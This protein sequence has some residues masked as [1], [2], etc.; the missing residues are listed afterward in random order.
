MVYDLLLKNG[1]LLNPGRGIDRVGD[2]AVSEGKLVYPAGDDIRAKKTVDVTGCFVLPG[3]IDIH[4]HLNYLGAAS[5]MPADLACIPAGVTAVLDAGSTGVSNAPSLAKRLRECEVKTKFMLNVSATG[6]IMANQ[7]PESVDPSVWDVGLF[8]AIFSTYGD[9]I[10][11][12]KIRISKSVV[13]EMGLEPLKKAIELSERYGVPV[14]VHTTNPPVS[15]GEVA[16]VLRKGDILTHLYHGSGMTCI[17]EGKVAAGYW[18]ARKRGVLFDTA[19]GQGNLSLTV[20]GEAIA[21]GFRPDTISTDLNIYN[22]NHDFVF[23]L[24]VMMAKFLA[25]GMSLDEVVDCV[26]E[27]PARQWGAAGDMGCL[28]EGT[29]ADITVLKQIKRSMHYA[30]K[31]GNQI[32]GDTALIPMMTVINGRTR[33]QATELHP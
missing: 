31:Y 30:D 33:Y 20:A 11:A 3:L 17:T 23:S 15:M 6:I 32:T 2:L 1:H 13:R 9:R 4:A 27:A 19:C 10:P 14:C 18:E 25:L 22:W 26:T 24:P 21:Q 29:S 7:F 28:L 8:D 16:S 5:G 12:L